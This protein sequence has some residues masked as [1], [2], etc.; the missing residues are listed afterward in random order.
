MYCIP[1]TKVNHAATWGDALSRV[2]TNNHSSLLII[3]LI[4]LPVQILFIYSIKYVMTNALQ[5]SC[6]AHLEQFTTVLQKTLHI[7]PGAF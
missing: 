7:I 1:R 5:R 3:L 4:K 2:A 6:F